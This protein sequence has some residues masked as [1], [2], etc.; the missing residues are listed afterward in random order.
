MT[1]KLYSYKKQMQNGSQEKAQYHDGMNTK[2]G[3]IALKARLKDSK[4]KVSKYKND[5]KL[6][7]KI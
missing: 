4:Y 2:D 5:P 7:S 3:D 1:K 6:T